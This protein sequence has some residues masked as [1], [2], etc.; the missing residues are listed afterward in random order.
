M[1]MYEPFLNMDTDNLLN[2]F[3]T[4][5][6]SSDNKKS[7]ELFIWDKLP[8]M[9]YKIFSL[10]YEWTGIFLIVYNFL[11]ESILF[12]KNSLSHFDMHI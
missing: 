3:K 12:L 11:G 5:K 2:I 4:V 9:L 1:P 10:F 6:R 8:R 7:S